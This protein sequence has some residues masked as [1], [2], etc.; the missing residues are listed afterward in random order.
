MTW[1]GFPAIFRVSAELKEPMMRNIRCRACPLPGML[2]IENL[3]MDYVEVSLRLYIISPRSV[4]TT[5][6]AAIMPSDF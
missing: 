2:L 4:E 5:G 1:N 3:V 6:F